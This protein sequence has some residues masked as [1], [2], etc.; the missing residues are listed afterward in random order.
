MAVWISRGQPKLKAEAR[1]RCRAE[2][3]VETSKADA[4]GK[5]RQGARQRT[6]AVLIGT[7]E[8]GL[9][10]F[11]DLAVDDECTIRIHRLQGFKLEELPLEGLNRARGHPGH[12]AVHARGGTATGRRELGR[13]HCVTRGCEATCGA[14]IEYILAPHIIGARDDSRMDSRVIEAPLSEVPHQLRGP[15]QNTEV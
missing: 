4:Q 11:S 7:N 13:A 3:V 5:F 9:K 10:H 8:T 1:G 12:A 6:V 14:P 15:H 2:A